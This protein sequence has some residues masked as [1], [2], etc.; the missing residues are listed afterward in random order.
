MIDYSKQLERIK[1]KLPIA[2]KTDKNLKVFGADKHK[3]V[4][5]KPVSEREILNFEQLYSISLPECYKS[6]LLHI[7]NGGI[8]SKNSGAG[9]YY[10]LYSF[11]TK[12]EELVYNNLREHL[13]KDCI[14]SPRM[15]DE[16]WSSLVK[17]F[18]NDHISDDER[19]EAQEK[20]FGGILPIGSQGCAYIHGL[21]L[22][23]PYKG[24]V[25]K[26]DFD[27]QNKTK[28]TF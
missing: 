13:K 11:G 18:D 5:N 22:N 6:F 4:L 9:P 24:R 26:L 28:F 14:V 1:A 3:Y 7:G 12:V 2:R 20:I 25:V 19:D 21:V 16:Y 23:G 17:I 10:G 8:D 15:S 27:K